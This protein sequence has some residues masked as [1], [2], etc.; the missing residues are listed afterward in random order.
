MQASL[1]IDK[2][3]VDA[4]AK[5]LTVKDALRASPDGGNVVDLEMTVLTDSE[6]ISVKVSTFYCIINFPTFLPK[7]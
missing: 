3:E 2:M 6:D 4:D 7:I 5:F 1:T